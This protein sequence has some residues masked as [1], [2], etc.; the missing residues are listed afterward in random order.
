MPSFQRSI[1]SFFSLANNFTFLNNLTEVGF[2]FEWT[3]RRNLVFGIKPNSS[4]P[5]RKREE[6][7]LP[8]FHSKP[9]QFNFSFHSG[10]ILAW[11]IQLAGLFVAGIHC[12]KTF[13]RKQTKPTYA[14]M[15]PTTKLIIS[16]YHMI[17]II[18]TVIIIS[19]H[20]SFGFTNSNL[21]RSEVSLMRTRWMNLQWRQNSAS[22]CLSWPR[23]KEW[24]AGWI[25]LMK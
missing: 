12:A 23:R 24:V 7:R 15:P 10:G 3:W 21:R 1:N 8:S 4:Q 18:H 9:N 17:C 5:R 13:C 25:S 6:C 20:S 16:C 14:S 11:S 2:E 22:F 19:S